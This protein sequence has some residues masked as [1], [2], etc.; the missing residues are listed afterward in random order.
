MNCRDC[1]TRTLGG[2]G[3]GV[4]TTLPSVTA[5][6]DFLEGKKGG[7]ANV[8]LS[9]GLRAGLIGAGLYVA[10]EREKLLKYSVYGA[11]AIEAFVLVYINSQL[12]K[13]PTTPEALGAVQ[14]KLAYGALKDRWQDDKGFD[15]YLGLSRRNYPALIPDDFADAGWVSKF[16]SD[17]VTAVAAETGSSMADASF[18]E[19]TTAYVNGIVDVLKTV[20]AATCNDSPNLCTALTQ[21]PRTR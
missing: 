15:L 4:T 10:G 3:A 7:F 21:Q 19:S 9:T 1:T 6:E 11:L 12:K 5:A 8:V 18:V 16:V 14:R 13:A 2:L 20:A 17:K